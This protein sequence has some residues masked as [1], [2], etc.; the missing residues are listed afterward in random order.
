[1]K[2]ISMH[3]AKN[4]H[5]QFVERAASRKTIS[6]GANGGAEAKPDPAT[7]VE[8]SGKQIGILTGN[9]SVLHDFDAPLPDDILEGF[10]GPLD[11]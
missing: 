11:P 1:M 8:S 10:Q 5:S 9:L 2:I 3:Q 7:S 4:S 6:V